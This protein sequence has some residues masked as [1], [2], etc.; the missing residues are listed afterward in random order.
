MSRR[1]FFHLLRHKCSTVER[2]SET[3]QRFTDNEDVDAFV[4]LSFFAENVDKNFL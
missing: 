4:L 1:Q 3:V 2:E